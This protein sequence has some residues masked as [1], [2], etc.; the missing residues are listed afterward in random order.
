ME[1]QL[2][3]QL[4]AKNQ[5]SAGV[6]DVQCWQVSFQPILPHTEYTHCSRDAWQQSPQTMTKT[7]GDIRHGQP[8]CRFGNC[9]FVEQRFSLTGRRIRA[10]NT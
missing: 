4:V 3:R 2:A 1:W 10:H 5:E 7:Y 6:V 8:L 9:T